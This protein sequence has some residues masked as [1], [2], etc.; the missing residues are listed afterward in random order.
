M[1][2][3]PDQADKIVRYERALRAEAKFLESLA[4]Q[5]R[6]NCFAP[7]PHWSELAKRANRLRKLLGDDCKLDPIKWIT[8]YS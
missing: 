4:I 1:S 6:T 3:A 7:G 8:P 5:Q 2:D